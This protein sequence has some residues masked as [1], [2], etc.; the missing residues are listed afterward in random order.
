MTAAFIEDSDDR[1]AGRPAVAAVPDGQIRVEDKLYSTQKLAD[2]HPG[3]PLFVKAF[4]GRDASLAFISYHRR[5]FPHSGRAKAALEGVDPSVDYTQ[6][7]HAD[8]M[9]LC[10][11]V[12]K[13]LPRMKSFAPWYYFIKVAFLVGGIVGMEAYCHY[14]AYYGFPL[15]VLVGLFAA[16]IGLNVQHDANHGAVSRNPRV[17]R[18]L[19]L[20]QSW[21]GGSSVSWI[22]QHVVQHH[23]HTNDLHL[24]PDITGSDILRLNPLEPLMKYQLFQHV[25]FFVLLAL[26]GFSVVVQAIGNVIRGSHHTPMSPLLKSER[27]LDLCA[28]IFYLF[29]W[30][31]L[32]VMRTGSLTVLFSTIPTYM[33]AGYYLAFFF[34]LS[35]NFEG[36]HMQ[37]DTTRPS[38]KGSKEQSFLYKQ[39][40]TSSNVGGSLLCHLNGGLNYQ[41]EHHLF[42]RVNHCHYPLIAP[43]VRQFCEEKGI[44]YVHFASISENVSSTARHLFDMGHNEKPLK[45]KIA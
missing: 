8:Y 28:G 16:L 29:R 31:A 37:S 30:V 9:E 22:H 21:I 13:V 6:E 27:T 4:S 17:N 36:V 20:T 11:R 33:V 26:Y 24:D 43:V 39:I 7:D 3:G 35:H 42:P 14:N 18:L 41:I 12:G 38:N 23:V 1:T 5:N 45:A 2:L 32:P 25:Y 34:S 44:P 40:A 10:D 19:G 15:N